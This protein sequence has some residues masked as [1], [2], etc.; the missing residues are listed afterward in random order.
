MSTIQVRSGE[1]RWSEVKASYGAQKR[2]AWVCA[3][4]G[5]KDGPTLALTAGQHGMEPTGPAILSGLAR[6][7]SPDE[8]S[9]TLLVVPMVYAN[10][11]RH[12]YECEPIRGREKAVARAGRWH[13]ECPYGFKR[14]ECGRNFNR[15]WGENKRESVHTRLAAALWERVVVPAQ[16]LIDLH[17]WQDWAPPGVLTTSDA[18]L[19]L[20]RFTGVPWIVHRTKKSPLDKV[21]LAERVIGSGRVAL[22]IEFTPQTRIVAD[23]AARGR[24][25][26]ANVMRRLKMLPGTAKPTR[27]LYVLGEKKRDWRPVKAAADVLVMPTIR[28][29]D[30]VERGQPV[31]RLVEIDR[32]W[33]MAVLRAPCE[34][35]VWS[36]MGSSA[37]RKGEQMMLFRRAMRL[38]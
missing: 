4:G 11:L 18:A 14:N 36:T 34:S 19:Q 31:A 16:Y 7:L 15:M 5:R 17:C 30:W 10:A 21:M 8:L 22:T 12:G 24:W 6:D 38:A 26:L 32:P 33:K 29:G 25:G 3:I 1:K 2:S 20:A 28:P 27:P 23:M 13:N 37:V 35:L 9:G